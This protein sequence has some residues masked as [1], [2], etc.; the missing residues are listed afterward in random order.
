MG[1]VRDERRQWS[2]CACVEV[3]LMSLLFKCSLCADNLT[4]VSAIVAT[5][6]CSARPTSFKSS[7]AIVLSAFLRR[8]SLT[9]HALWSMRLIESLARDCFCGVS[10][11][12]LYLLNDIF[13]RFQK[14]PTSR[15]HIAL[16]LGVM[17]Q[18][19]HWVTGATVPTHR[20]MRLRL[21]TALEV[22]NS[23]FST[24]AAHSKATVEELLRRGKKDNSSRR[25]LD[26]LY[27]LL[28]KWQPA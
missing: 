22:T 19:T 10:R 13:P 23:I 9:V 27:G 17:K 21:I 18:C 24:K 4:T 16:W 20:P 26:A 8:D 5:H 11:A 25:R 15:S 7:L 2:L 12:L 14:P 6:S 3:L 28:A 1:R